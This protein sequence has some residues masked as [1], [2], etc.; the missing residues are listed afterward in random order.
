VLRIVS[1]NERPDRDPVDRWLTL[2]QA[3]RIAGVHPVTM[4]LW[5]DKGLVPYIRTA[6]GH[7]RFSEQALH[8]RTVVHGEGP[9]ALPP[10]F[11][12]GLGWTRQRLADP[13][14]PR[15]VSAHFSQQ[16]REA[17]R[18]DGRALLGLVMHYASQPEEDSGLLDEAH[19][20][21]DRYA[22]M[23]ISAGLP[24]TEAVATVQFFRDALVESVVDTPAV[25]QSKMDTVT[26]VRRINRMLNAYQLGLIERYVGA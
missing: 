25:K 13:E 10:G 17:Q 12:R 3:A 9:R 14:A 1:A 8:E 21:G 6:G 18:S 16:Q 2:A 23:C 5:A 7:R 11:E 22:D 19:R 15:T 4:R 20:I 24:L 26:I